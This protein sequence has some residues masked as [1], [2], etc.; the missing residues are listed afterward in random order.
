MGRGNA[1]G[2][3]LLIT[4]SLAGSPGHK[5]LAAVASTTDGFELSQLDLEMRREGDVLGS[6]QSGHL[7]SLRLLEVVRDEDVIDR[8]RV[9]ARELIENDPE[10]E[11]LPSLR[12]AIADLTAE[13]QTDF[14]EKA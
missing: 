11:H 8:A 2:L 7:S 4:D 3:C 10:L 1:P 5:R 6:V 14:I 9:Q 13:K 12:R